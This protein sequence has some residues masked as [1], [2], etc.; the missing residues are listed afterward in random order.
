[1]HKSICKNHLISSTHS[2][3]HFQDISLPP[4]PPTGWFDHSRAMV[5]VLVSGFQ[6]PIPSHFIIDHSLFGKVAPPFVLIC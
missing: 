1:M 5:L 3:E 4:S 2:S 6:I